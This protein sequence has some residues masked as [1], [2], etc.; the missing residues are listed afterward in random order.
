MD[1]DADG[2]LWLVLR[3][4]NQVY[5]LDLESGL[6]HHKA[7]TGEKGFAGNGGTAVEATLSGPKG[8]ALAPNGDAYLVD[9]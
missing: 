2:N 8:I 5:K 6:M 1:F 9:T 4:G 3:N 7:G